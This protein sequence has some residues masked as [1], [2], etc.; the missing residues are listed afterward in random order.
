MTRRPDERLG[1][2]SNPR[3]QARPQPQAARD[4]LGRYIERD[5][6]HLAAE[7]SANLWPLERLRD[8][9]E[10]AVSTTNGGVMMSQWRTRPRLISALAVCVL[11]AGLLIVPVHYQRTVGHRIE[12]DTGAGLS[13]AALASLQHDLENLSGA[14]SLQV[15]SWPSGSVRLG[16]SLSTA[17]EARAER[18]AEILVERVRVAAP[19]ASASVE[20]IVETVSGNVYAMVLEQIIV[21]DVDTTGKTDR[22]VEDE[23]RAQLAAEGVEAAEVVYQ[24]GPDSAELRVAGEREG[25]V[26]ELVQAEVGEAAPT[27]VRMEIGWL[28]TS[29]DEGMTDEELVAK[30]RAQLEERGMSG[31]VEV[32][33][34][35]IRVRVGKPPG[36]GDGE[37][38]GGDSETAGDGQATVDIEIDI[39]ADSDA[40]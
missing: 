23:I 25:E 20:P 28:D 5:R 30:I 26:F 10:A 36:G 1:A 21:I 6:A 19:G 35:D 15:T 7:S 33:G 18:V 8:L 37:G 12:V 39:E 3:P 31:D 9:R 29:R 32:D 34:D 24:R 38:D 22:E 11:A 17:S 14:H 2:N 16:L 40:P 4:A 27:Q 13:A